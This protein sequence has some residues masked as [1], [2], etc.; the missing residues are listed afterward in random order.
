MADLDAIKTEIAPVLEENGVTLKAIHQP[1][2]GDVF[3]IDLETIPGSSPNQVEET[4]KGMRKELELAIGSNSF[5]VRSIPEGSNM[6]V[7]V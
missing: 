4:L 6:N 5:F 2:S 3:S 1:K 7:T